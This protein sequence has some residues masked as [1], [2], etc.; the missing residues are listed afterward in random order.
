VAG[1]GVG[2]SS[3]VVSVPDYQP[4][5]DGQ[6]LLAAPG[7]RLSWSADTVRTSVLAAVGN[8]TA[9]A[10]ERLVEVVPAETGDVIERALRD[11][12]GTR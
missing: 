11:L 8:S 2:A 5:T 9:R 7:A 12:R 1:D 6:A 3:S 10:W 4:G